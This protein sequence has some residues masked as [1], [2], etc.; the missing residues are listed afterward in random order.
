MRYLGLRIFAAIYSGAEHC[1][2]FKIALFAKKVDGSVLDVW[3]D[4]EYASVADIKLFFFKLT[5]F[6]TYRILNN[7]FL[8]LAYLYPKNYFNLYRIH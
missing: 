5:H 4:P 1:Q 6:Q 2:T 8:Q 3:Q 7:F